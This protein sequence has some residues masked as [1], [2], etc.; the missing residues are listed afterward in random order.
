ML[1]LVGIM[2]IMKIINIKF[3]KEYMDVKCGSMV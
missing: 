3:I 1:P 2:N